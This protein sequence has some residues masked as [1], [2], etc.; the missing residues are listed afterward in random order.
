MRILNSLHAICN[1]PILIRN[2]GVIDY[3][4]K[5]INSTRGGG[6]IRD[7]LQGL[8]GAG[9]QGF[10]A[11]MDAWGD[12][13]LAGVGHG[14]HFQLGVKVVDHVERDGFGGFGFNR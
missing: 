14:E 2:S 8:N 11:L 9:V 1:Q 6:L 3:W 5:A 13:G 4:H 10:D 7:F 12:F